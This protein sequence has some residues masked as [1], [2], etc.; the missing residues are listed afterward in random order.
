MGGPRGI[1]RLLLAAD[2]AAPAWPGVDVSFD[3]D[4]GRAERWAR[5]SWTTAGGWVRG[6]R[7]RPALVL[8]VLTAALYSLASLA[9]YGHGRAGLDL[10]IFTEAVSRYAHGHMPWS[11]AKGAGGFNLLGDHFSPL[12]ALLAVPYLVVPD[13]RTL[14]VAQAVLV[15]TAAG[16]LTRAALRRLP[17]AVALAAGGAYALAWGTQTLALFDVHEVALALPLLAMA[18]TAYLDR[19]YWA[20]MGWSLPL[21]AVKEDSVFLLLGLAL[22]VAAARR[23]AQAAVLAVGAVTT[24]AVVVGVIVPHLSWS[25]R[26]TYWD[27]APTSGGHPLSAP[28]RQL[29]DALASGQGL[30]LVGMLLLPTL[31]LALR[32]PLVLAVVPSLLSRLASPDEVY[33]G[34][35]YHYNGTVTVLLAFAALD[36][37]VRS[38][39]ASRLILRGQAAVAAAL[40][41]PALAVLPWFPLAGALVSAA[42][43]CTARC[44]G[45][46]QLQWNLVTLSLD[47]E[48]VAADR[49]A[50]PYLAAGAYTHELLPGLKDTTGARIYPR[51]IV[52]DCAPGMNYP[53]VIGWRADLVASVSEQYMFFRWMPGSASNCRWAVWMARGPASTQ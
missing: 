24:F 19:R 49:D 27:A 32:S 9:R 39:W 3:A 25:R 28:L 53:Y 46:G 8:G 45:I 51:Y 31:G 48:S 47:H 1:G 42:Q 20:V 13:P 40:L 11:L 12:M 17:R 50:M 35:R 43:P 26:W 4:L 6:L 5:D 41:L 14:L 38:G 29:T 33:R 52:M 21:M 34:L 10:A 7:A 18:C 16:L 30:L 36:G 44:Q 2:T 22:A 23:W 37:L 15:G